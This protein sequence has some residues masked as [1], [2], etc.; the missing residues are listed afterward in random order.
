MKYSL[1]ALILSLSV[2]LNAQAPTQQPQNKG[3]QGSAQSSGNSNSGSSSK[4]ASATTDQKLEKYAKVKWRKKLKI[5]RK[6]IEAGSYISASEYLEDVFKDKPDKTEVLHLL[7][8]VNRLLRDYEAA[9]KYYKLSLQKSPDGFIDDSYHL[10]L[11][12]KMNGK[13]DDAKK[14]LTDY[15]KAKLDKG[16]KSYKNQAKIDIEG[17]DS[18]Q[19]ILKNPS[20][21]KVEKTVGINAVLQDLSPQPLKGNRIL[22]AQEKTDTALD[23]TTTKADYY[24]SIFTAEKSGKAYINKTLLPYPPNSKHANTGNAILSGDEKTMIY[25]ICNDSLDEGNHARCKFT[26]QPKRMHWSG[27]NPKN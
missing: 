5:A 14:T 17:I 20:K 23:N 9:E 8:D 18:A 22:F 4:G 10:G 1:L 16:D 11:M 25:T 26:E 13:Y 7:G 24:A 12:Q 3:G 21:I 15:L 2:L 19:V 6:E 27:M